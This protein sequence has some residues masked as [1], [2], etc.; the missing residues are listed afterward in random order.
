MGLPEISTSKPLPLW[1]VLLEITALTVSPTL[2]VKVMGLLLW[3][4]LAVMAT[5]P[6]VSQKVRVVKFRQS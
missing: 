2:T 6:K 1:S 3:V 5:T 4:L